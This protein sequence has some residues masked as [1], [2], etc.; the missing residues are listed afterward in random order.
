MKPIKNFFYALFTLGGFAAASTVLHAQETSFQ[1]ASAKS[2]DALLQAVESTTPLPAGYATNGVNFYSA[3]HAPGSE[4]EWPPLPGNVLGLDVWPLGDNTF[5]LDDNTVNYSDLYGGGGMFAMSMDPNDPGDG[6]D[7]TNSYS[8]NITPNLR[9]PRTT[10]GWKSLEPRII[11]GPNLTAFLVIHPPWNVTNGVY[12]LY[13]TTNLSKDVAGLNYTNW[14]WVLRTDPGQTNLTVTNLTDDVAF[15]RLG[16]PNNLDWSFIQMEDL[17]AGQD[18]VA[19]TFTNAISTIISNRVAWNVKLFVSAG[20]LYEND[21]SPNHYFFTNAVGQALCGASMTNQLWRLRNVGISVMAVEGNHEELYPQASP[22][23]WNGIFGTNFYAN[24]PMYFTNRI[25]NDTRDFAMKMTNGTSKYL[26][27]GLGWTN[28][29]DTNSAYGLTFANTNDMIAAYSNSCVWAK[30][31]ATSLPDHQVIAVCHY[32]VDTAGN[33]STKDNPLDPDDPSLPTHSYINEGPGIV[34]W[35]QLKTLSS[36]FLVLSGHVRRDHMTVS[37]L[38]ANDGHTV[39]SV[40]FNTQNGSEVISGTNL[41]NGG[42]FV[43]YTVQPALHRV[44]ARVYSSDLGRFLVGGEGSDN[45]YRPE[46]V[47]PTQ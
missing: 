19:T 13:Y 11:M 3:Q 10:F 6:D 2:L 36:P 40:K 22:Y 20:D 28:N 46:F 12:D 5:L 7:G 34:L 37:T 21:A 4:E 18:L 33:P 31:I 29:P 44:V 30:N 9:P 45:K 16:A 43:L 32:F 1:G 38:T 41:N 27:I 35:N 14:Q 15:Y 17:H 25:V 23:P 47:F 26:F 8:L 39:Q 24:E 42:T